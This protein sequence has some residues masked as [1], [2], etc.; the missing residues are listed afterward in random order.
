MGT[1]LSR[2]TRMADLPRN[3]T[4]DSRLWSVP[5]SNARLGNISQSALTRA[6]SSSAVGSWG[7]TAYSA[8]EAETPGRN[9]CNISR[10]FGAALDFYL[11]IADR[12]RN[13]TDRMENKA[14]GNHQVAV[15]AIHDHHILD[16]SLAGDGATRTEFD[17]AAFDGRF[18]LSL[19]DQRSARA[20]STFELDDAAD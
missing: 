12:A 1:S 18:D 2:M 16:R 5:L 6:S 7:D 9:R 4:N 14:P 11:P 17:R 13:S 20:N 3:G 15:K 19:E 10:N 8:K